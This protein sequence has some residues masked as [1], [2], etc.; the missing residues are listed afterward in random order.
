[1]YASSIEQKKIMIVYYQNNIENKVGHN[2][3]Q[4]ALAAPPDCSVQVELT[5]SARTGLVS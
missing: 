1:M 2:L 3:G 5:P 4:T